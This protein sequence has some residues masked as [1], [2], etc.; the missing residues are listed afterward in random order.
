MKSIT[1]S[2]STN[3]QDAMNAAR[4]RAVN[5]VGQLERN[6]GRPTF[7]GRLT[8]EQFAELTVVHNRKWAEDA[9]ESMDVVTQREILDAHANGLA[10]FMLQGLI[11]A[12]IRRL[13]EQQTG[14]PVLEVL[15]RFQDRVGRSAHYG[16]PQVTLVLTGEPAVTPLKEGEDIVAARIALPSGRLFFVADGQH[17]REAARRVRDFLND[18][19]ATRRIPS[20]G[21]FYPHSDTPMTADEMEAWV[22]IYETFRTWTLIS[23]EAHIGL[24]VEEA[25]QMF[26]NYNC[27]VKP[28]K[29]DLS[30]EFD[31]SNPINTFAKEWVLEQMEAV[32]GGPKLGLRELA[33]INGFLFL[34]K[35]TIKSAPYD[36]AEILPIAKEFWTSVVQLREW[37]RANS[38]LHELPVL[39]ALA[40]AWFYVFVARRNQRRDKS[41]ELRA[42][43]RKT[44]FDRNWMESVPGLKVHTVPAAG[45]LGFRFS[46]AHNDIVARI[47]EHAIG[48]KPERPK[49]IKANG[50]ARID[51]DSIG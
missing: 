48:G 38:L 41:E 32:P 42:Y 16:L 7:T 23:F 20:K 22:A 29:M 5:L 2:E 35:T 1:E 33:T 17:R 26:T 50:R 37:R 13:P 3:I 27:H 19:I 34:G 11:D 8:L 36:V 6:Q 25:R 40:K 39:K 28:V 45:E 21:K 46:P 15:E 44:V 30:L 47:V 14:S 31:Q 4:Q 10:T 18:L 24:T 49:A 9:G 12:T 51:S 43:I